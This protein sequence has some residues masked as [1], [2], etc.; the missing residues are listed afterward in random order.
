MGI[1]FRSLGKN[2]ILMDI[3]FSLQLVFIKF[4]S[5]NSLNSWLTYNYEL[6]KRGFPTDP[7]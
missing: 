3:G 4:D 1:N 5:M 2:C 6:P 7:Q